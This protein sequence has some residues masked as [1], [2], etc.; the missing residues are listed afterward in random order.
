MITSRFLPAAAVLALALGAAACS[1]GTTS[2]STTGASTQ[3]QRTTEP[4]PATTSAVWPLAAST[5][6]YSSPEGAATGFA[7]QYLG[8]PAPVVGSFAQGDSRSGE[9]PVR[10]TPTGPITTVLVRQ[11][12]TGSS[13]WVLGCEA[14]DITLT[15]PAWDAIVS[16]P[17]SLTGSSL[18]FE[19]TVQTQVR[20]DGTAQPLGT[21]FVTGGSAEKAPFSGALDF[22]TPSASRG[23]VVLQAISAKDGSVLEASVVRVRLGGPTG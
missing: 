19:G 17:V 2:S 14:Q 23:A 8:M 20:Q 3:P 15:T 13:W 16:S 18:A 5:T 11:L 12:G 7:R 22:T 6:R 4:A 10:S 21:G 9:V 1:S